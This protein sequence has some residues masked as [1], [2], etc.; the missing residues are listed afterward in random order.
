MIVF[1]YSSAL[2]PI[3]SVSPVP[4]EEENDDSDEDG[5]QEFKKGCDPKLMSTP[6]LDVASDP[7]LVKV[8]KG[9]LVRC[10]NASSISS[11]RSLQL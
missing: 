8:R 2:A 11:P 7:D 1:M 5:T 4:E 6:L 10:L 3:L 9:L